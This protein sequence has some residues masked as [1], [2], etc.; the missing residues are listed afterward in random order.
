MGAR[1]GHGFPMYVDPSSLVDTVA[2]IVHIEDSRES[3]DGRFML[4]CRGTR[5]ARICECWVE[6]GT[7]Q[8][9][10]ARCS[11]LEE[12]TDAVTEESA[13]DLSQEAQDGDDARRPAGEQQEE[14]PH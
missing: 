11:V 10:M 5:P 9:F 3:P 7:G 6:E 12:A 8:L 2:C 14:S 13:T 1:N 4:Q